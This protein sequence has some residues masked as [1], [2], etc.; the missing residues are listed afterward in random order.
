MHNQNFIRIFTY[1]KTDKAMKITS[2]NIINSNNITII[3]SSLPLSKHWFENGESSLLTSDEYVTF[4]LEI[5]GTKV[6]FNVQADLEAS[7]TYANSGGDGYINESYDEV[8]EVDYTIDISTPYCDDADIAFDVN[9]TEVQTV[10]INLITAF[11]C[12]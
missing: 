2:Q 4:E 11:I 3:E 6:Q 5:D 8:D 10:L 12:K 7:C 1:T 9:D